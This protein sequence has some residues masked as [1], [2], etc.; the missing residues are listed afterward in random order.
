[1]ATYFTLAIYAFVTVIMVGI[2]AAQIRSKSPVSF[3]TGETPPK[4]TEILD[5][6]AWNRKHGW[7]FVGYGAVLM[8]SCIA[9]SLCQGTAVRLILLLGGVALPIPC[10]ILY[11]SMLT[12]QYRK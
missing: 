1:M 8:L 7:M 2:G 5:V 6:K 3:F 9:A 12:G 4:E 10:M 11:H